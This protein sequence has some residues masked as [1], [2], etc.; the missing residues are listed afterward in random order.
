MSFDFNK[1]LKENKLGPYSK[2]GN[3]KKERLDEIGYVDLKP[4]G[5]APVPPTKDKIYKSKY[6]TEPKPGVDISDMNIDPYWYDG[7]G[8]P[9]EDAPEWF[10]KALGYSSTGT[11]NDEFTDADFDNQMSGAPWHDETLNYMD[12]QGGREIYNSMKSLHDNGFEPEDI[13]AFV[14]MCMEMITQGVEPDIEDSWRTN[15]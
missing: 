1:Y 7:D 2:I 11:Q 4:I 5:E 14:N 12:G 9:S 6:D 3:S 8:G 10:K 13:F 15:K